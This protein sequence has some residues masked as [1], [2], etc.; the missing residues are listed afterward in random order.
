MMET[1]YPNPFPHAPL[2]CSDSAVLR[3]RVQCFLLDGSSDA[4]LGPRRMPRSDLVGFVKEV[5]EGEGLSDK[6]IVLDH[7]SELDRVV[8]G[9]GCQILYGQ[10]LCHQVPAV[11]RHRG[12]GHFDVECPLLR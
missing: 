1:P 7:W 3:E 4:V 9:D 10:D 6:F 2:S 8:G 5:I 11:V 12:D